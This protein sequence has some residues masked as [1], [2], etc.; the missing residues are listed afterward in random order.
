MTEEKKKM[1]IGVAG[2]AVIILLLVKS[3]GP[4]EQPQEQNSSQEMK[5]A[6]KEPIPSATFFN[7]RHNEHV[8]EVKE[9]KS[10]PTI[11]R[12]LNVYLKEPIAEIEI[13][14]IAMALHNEAPNF[15]RT[16]I[17]Y[18]LPGMTYGAG[19]WA[20]SHFNPD[21]EIKIFGFKPDFELSA[22]SQII[23]STVG[24]WTSWHTVITIN[25]TDATYSVIRETGNNVAWEEEHSGKETERG[26][27]LCPA[28]L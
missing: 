9:N 22:T 19:A 2:W 7:P 1:V 6:P 5:V 8:L 11:K 21:L 24:Q 13:R 28:P 23:D 16:F 26:L 4:E 15:E 25:K 17:E 10:I 3:C 20:I 27:L 14:Q 18:L 12:S